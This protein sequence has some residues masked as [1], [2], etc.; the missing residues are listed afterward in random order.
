MNCALRT[1]LFLRDECRTFKIV[2]A[3]GVYLVESLKHNHS[4]ACYALMHGVGDNAR[5]FNVHSSKSLI[6]TQRAAI[7]ALCLVARL[8]RTVNN[9]Q[10]KQSKHSIDGDINALRLCVFRLRDV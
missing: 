2:R 1:R 6:E 10:D 4:D 7:A 5:T 9:F 8:S 3:N